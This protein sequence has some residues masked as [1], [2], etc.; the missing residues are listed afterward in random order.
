MPFI[1][2]TARLEWLIAEALDA[3]ALPPASWSNS[4]D[5]VDEDTMPELILQPSL[6][7][8]FSRWPALDIWSAHQAG[9]DLEQL[10]GIGSASRERI[11]LWRNRDSVRFHPPQR[12]AL[13]ISARA[14]EAARSLNMP[15]KKAAARAPNFDIVGSLGGAL[16]RRTRRH[17]SATNLHKP[18][19]KEW[20]DDHDDPHIHAR[21]R[22]SSSAFIRSAL[23]LA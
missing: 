12:C 13:R 4:H 18:I 1:A 3:P 20:I 21:T 15:V 5:G 23:Q 14:E 7:L 2:D 10:G 17:A 22:R 8:L 11:A 16:C 9:G 6:R 19:D